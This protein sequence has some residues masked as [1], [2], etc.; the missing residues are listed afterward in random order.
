MYSKRVSVTERAEAIDSVA[1][2]REL[3][4]LIESITCIVG[5]SLHNITFL[6]FSTYAQLTA[7]QDNKLRDGLQTIRTACQSN[8]PEILVDIQAHRHEQ[9]RPPG[10][11]PADSE[12]HRVHPGAAG[13]HGNREMGKDID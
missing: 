1:A 2:G 13:R 7:G 5:R 9:P 4:V 6:V 10:L 11:T 12:V 8:F 3:G